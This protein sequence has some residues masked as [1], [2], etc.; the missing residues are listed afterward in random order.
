MGRVAK[1][2]KVKSFDPYS[3]KNRGNVDLPMVGVW[4]LGDNGRR[5]KK[6]SQKAERMHARKNKIKKNSKNKFLDDGG[7]DAPPIGKDEFDMADLVGSIKR[8][9]VETMNIL[10]EN[11]S[12]TTT[13]SN[14]VA[15]SIKKVANESYDRIVTSTGNIANI[16]KSDQDETKVTRLLR[17]DK[18]DERKAELEKRHARMDGESKRA[19]AKR[20]RA[21]TREIIKNSTTIRNHEKLQKKKEFLKNKKSKKRKGGTSFYN[22]NESTNDGPSYK[23]NG[24]GDSFQEDVPVFGEQAERPP[25]FRQIPRGAKSKETKSKSVKP[26]QGMSE[27]QIESERKAMD[28]MRRRI[29]AQY[30]AIKSKRRDDGDFH[31]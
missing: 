5:A 10:G 1:Y 9:K 8:Q 20:V 14:S 16:P 22:D 21:E 3:K 31:L 15:S 13:N 28:L 2:K 27:D 18:Q 26:V 25:I 4:G 6:R 24:D 19:Y 7:F 11:T 29:H 12:S 30:K 17:L 23:A